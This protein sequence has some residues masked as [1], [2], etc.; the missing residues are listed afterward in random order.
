MAV[1]PIEAAPMPKPT[2]P[3]SVK[4]VLKTR[5]RPACMRQFDSHFPTAAKHIPNS[6]ARPMVHRKTPPKATSSPNTTAESSLVKAKLQSVTSSRLITLDQISDLPH[7]VPNCLV[8]VHLPCLSSL[9]HVSYGTS[10]RILD[11]V[12]PCNTRCSK[13][14]IARCTQ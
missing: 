4:G 9:E 6:S 13:R 8:Q 2:I 3:C 5:S 10:R 11:F 1:C 12:C 7:G 14:G